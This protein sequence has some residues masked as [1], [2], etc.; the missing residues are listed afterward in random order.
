[1]LDNKAV[2]MHRGMEEGGRIH[3][4]ATLCLCNQCTYHYSIFFFFRGNRNCVPIYLYTY[5]HACCTTWM[6]CNHCCLWICIP[7]PCS[8][9]DVA[10]AACFVLLLSIFF[11][12][13]NT[14]IVSSFQWK[15]SFFHQHFNLVRS[16]VDKISDEFSTRDMSRTLLRWHAIEERFWVWNTETLFVQMEEK[17]SWSPSQPNF[18]CPLSTHKLCFGT[19]AAI[20]LSLHQFPEKNS[21]SIRI[22]CCIIGEVD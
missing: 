2:S 8:E 6:Y 20:Y 19:T 1:M 11:C 15:N 7:Y 5:T 3:Q 10:N 18:R 13:P 9:R 17:K 12:Q 14:I 16:H 21:C 22:L 4:S